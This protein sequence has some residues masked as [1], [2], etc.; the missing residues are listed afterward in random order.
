MGIVPAE[1][2]N[3]DDLL[4]DFE[5]DDFD[6]LATSIWGES[7][8]MEASSVGG[9]SSDAKDLR[10]TFMISEDDRKD[11]TKEMK[12]FID[13][14]KYVVYTS[15]KLNQ[16]TARWRDREMREHRAKHVNAVKTLKTIANAKT[17]HAIGTSNVAKHTLPECTKRA[18]EWQNW[19]SASS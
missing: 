9:D 7:S 6:E 11:R 14:S 10:N 4:T 2:D 15:K 18:Q 13:D 17:M 8:K 5:E 1:V 16:M 19:H 3:A 12:T